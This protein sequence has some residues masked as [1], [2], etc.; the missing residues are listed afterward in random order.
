ML[1]VHAPKTLVVHNAVYFGKQ[2][3]FKGFAG[4]RSTYNFTPK[5]I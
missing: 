1:F 4:R 3:I 2:K 5:I